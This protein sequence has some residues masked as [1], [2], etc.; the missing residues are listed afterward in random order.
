MS[1]FKSKAFIIAASSIGILATSLGVGLGVTLNSNRYKNVDLNAFLKDI[2]LDS[3]QLNK[4][5][6]QKVLLSETN[7][8]NDTYAFNVSN[9]ALNLKK[10]INVPNDIKIEFNLDRKFNKA[11]EL[12]DGEITIQIK[13]INSSDQ[14]VTKTLKATGFKK[15]D[16]ELLK[17]LEG[18]DQD[19]LSIINKNSDQTYISIE[20]LNSSIEIDLNKSD[21]DQMDNN[22]PENKQEINS[23]SLNW[24]N[25]ANEA[26][27]SQIDKKVFIKGEVKL[28]GI[29]K[30]LDKT[31]KS[32]YFYLSNKNNQASLTLA[33]KLDDGIVIE[34]AI[35]QIKTN[36]VAISEISIVPIEIDNEINTNYINNL[37]NHNYLVD[38][39]N[40]QQ[41]LFIEL[42]KAA[43]KGTN[44]L[45]VRPYLLQ[46]ATNKPIPL[47]VEI[48]F[49]KGTSKKTY[50]LDNENDHKT[51]I[52]IGLNLGIYSQNLTNKQ[53]ELLDGNEL[54]NA[55]LQ[56]SNY[57]HTGKYT[58]PEP[59]ANKKNEVYTGGFSLTQFTNNQLEN[60]LS[61]NEIIKPI[62]NSS[63]W[64][65]FAN[66]SYEGFESNKY[67]LTPSITLLHLAK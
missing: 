33:K 24:W 30:S 56:L 7:D 1:F 53:E 46:N 15:A 6:N 48:S 47:T 37:K 2:N 8:L 20:D 18:N 43:N 29:E 57:F 35:G 31:N 65:L 17:Y 59:I 3:I 54:K 40:E 9:S 58:N 64:L 52:E 66:Y 21:Q 49:G 28:D 5:N 38:S 42:N 11:K 44:N 36:K 51:L 63:N 19:L 14:F 62:D 13:A 22:Q 23:L 50:R 61:T 16:I 45:L 27:K 4:A 12:N 25:T 39:T 26:I 60:L 41:N 67:L 10:E 32:P 55:S 34:A